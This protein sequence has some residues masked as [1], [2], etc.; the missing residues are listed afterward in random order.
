VDDRIGSGL[1]AAVVGVADLMLGD[2]GVLEAVCLLLGREH[3]DVLAQRA[4][5]P[6]RARM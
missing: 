3:L 5:M 6:L 1:D 2:L 4:R